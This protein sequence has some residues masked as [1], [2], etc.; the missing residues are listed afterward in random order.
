LFEI[1]KQPRF[2]G[3]LFYA[4]SG[5]IISSN[6]G[7]FVP[8]RKEYEKDKKRGFGRAFNAD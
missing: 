7:H 2:K 5:K 4:Q 8:Q 6:S 3:L 1:P